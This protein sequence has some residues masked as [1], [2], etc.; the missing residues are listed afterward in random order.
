M[1]TLDKKILRT[2]LIIAAVVS[3]ILVLFFNKLTTPRFLSSI[4]LKINGYVLLNADRDGSRKE[5]PSILT[6][7]QDNKKWF[8]VVKGETEKQLINDLLPILKSPMNSNTDILLST[9]IIGAKL[10]EQ[11]PNKD[12]LIAVINNEGT[13]SGYFK[14][15][16]DRNKM[17][18]TYSSV[19]THR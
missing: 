12:N 14:P 4:E 3:V 7:D 5:S 18:L 8:I 1:N 11:L 13:L 16:F 9:Q 19:F 17:A 6:S 10:S 15:P 2:V